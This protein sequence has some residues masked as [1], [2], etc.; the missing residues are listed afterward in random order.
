[1]CAE[2]NVHTISFKFYLTNTMVFFFSKILERS[3]KGL[4]LG[5]CLSVHDT[6]MQQRLSSAVPPDLFKLVNGPFN[7]QANPSVSFIILQVHLNKL[8]CHGKVNL[9]Q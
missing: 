5:Y 1:M 3:T 7:H 6:C 4:S 8:E 2:K 9:F